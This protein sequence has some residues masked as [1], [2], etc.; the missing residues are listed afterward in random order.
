M[1]N[2]RLISNQVT[3]EVVPADREAS[4]NAQPTAE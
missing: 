4:S 1:L 2:G 3:F